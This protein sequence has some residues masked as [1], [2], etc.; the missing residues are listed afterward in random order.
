MARAGK[1]PWPVPGAIIKKERELLWGKGK[2][3][4][5]LAEVP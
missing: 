3:N 2:T 4:E 5:F 1:F